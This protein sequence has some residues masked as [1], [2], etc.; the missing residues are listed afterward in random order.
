MI[1][2]NY[3]ITLYIDY[4]VRMRDG[5]VL[6]DIVFRLQRPAANLKQLRDEGYNF[7]RT[8]VASVACGIP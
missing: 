1:L 5:Y 8:N 4:V 2:R 6:K 7:W 3:F